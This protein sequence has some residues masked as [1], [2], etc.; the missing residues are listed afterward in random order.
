VTYITRAY[1]TRHGAGPF[2][3]EDPSLSYP[4]TTN[5]EG[6]WQQRLRFGHLDIPLIREAIS[7]DLAQGREKVRSVT[8]AMT[9]LDQLPSLTSQFESSLASIELARPF[10]AKRLAGWGPT[11]DSLLTCS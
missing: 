3:T 10:G 8:I 7:N 6:P 2:P 9:H 1:M 5:V 4:D 11:R